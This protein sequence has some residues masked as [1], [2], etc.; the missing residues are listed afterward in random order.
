MTQRCIGT[1][2]W[3]WILENGAQRPDDLGTAFGNS[4]FLALRDLIV[5][6]GVVASE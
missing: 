1:E 3:K 5:V 6:R 4:A 2:I